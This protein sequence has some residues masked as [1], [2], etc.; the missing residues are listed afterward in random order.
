MVVLL[1]ILFISSYYLFLRQSIVFIIVIMYLFFQEFERWFLRYTFFLH[2]DLVE[3]TMVCTV[4]NQVVKYNEKKL[5]S[6]L[7]LAFS[8]LKGDLIKDL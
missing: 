1:Y 4:N 7:N 2:E 6:N 3:I 8:F 5:N